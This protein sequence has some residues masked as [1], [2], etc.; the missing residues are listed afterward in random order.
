MAGD[1]APSQGNTGQPPLREYQPSYAPD[2]DRA[3][4]V[5]RA[6]P[7]LK[8]GPTNRGGRAELS[9]RRRPGSLSLAR[10]SYRHAFL[11]PH[12]PHRRRRRRHPA[13]DGPCADLRVRH[14]EA[15]ARRGHERREL[16]AP[17]RLVHV[18]THHSRLRVLRRGMACRAAL[19]DRMASCRRDRARVRVG[20]PREHGHGHQP[21]SR[22]HDRARLLRRQRGQLGVGHRRDDPRLRAWR[23]ACRFGSS[24]R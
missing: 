15:V 12:R 22:S 18:F 1:N 13:L 5:T 16:A 3:K 19:S 20:D 10:A 6:P 21:L 14:G 17:Q 4:T 24:S 9:F 11:D 7:E 23:R 8:V 2:V